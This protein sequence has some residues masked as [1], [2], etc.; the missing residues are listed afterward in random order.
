[1]TSAALRGFQDAFT[2]AAAGQFGSGW[3]FLVVNPE[4]K[5]LEILALPNQDSVLLHQRPG[6]LTCDVWEH[7]YYLR[8]QNR[9]TEYLEAWWNVV[10]WDVVSRRL[11]NFLAGQQ[12][13]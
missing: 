12:Q 5:G 11:D 13:L 4:T 9:R 8:Y 2:S 6:L 3:V 7:A 1:M 10:A